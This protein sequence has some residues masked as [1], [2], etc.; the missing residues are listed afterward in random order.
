MF[1]ENC[2]TWEHEIFFY[3]EYPYGLI[4]IQK[5]FQVPRSHSIEEKCNDNLQ[6]FK[7][8]QLS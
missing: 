5:K 8:P 2:P 4:I 6:I 7:V 1:L 3:I